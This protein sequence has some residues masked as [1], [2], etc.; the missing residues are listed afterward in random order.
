[1]FR[2]QYLQF[3]DEGWNSIAIIDLEAI[4][5]N[6]K[7]L[8]DRSGAP[9]QMAVVKANAYG[10]GAVDI[11]I[12]VADMVDWFGVAGIREGIE[13]RRQGIMKPILVFGTPTRGSSS[14]YNEYGLT[15]TVSQ[16][17]HFDI[18]QPGT[19]YHIK[20]DTGMGRVGIRSEAAREIVRLVMSRPHLKLGGVMTH[21]ADA[22]ISGSIVFENQLRSF[23]TIRSLFPG[24]LIFHA[25]NSAASLHQSG[26][27]F[28]MIRS[29]VAMYGFDPR[30]D[31]NPWLRPALAW[32]SRLVQV[33]KMKAN[34]GVSYS[35]SF[36]MPHDGYIGVVPVGY[37][38]GIPRRLRN[39][40]RFGI[41]DSE[42]AQ[43]GNITMDQSMVF[44]GREPLS[45]DV[46]VLIMG[47]TDSLS[48]YR[49]ARLLGT[50][51]YEVTTSI[52]N[53]VLRITQ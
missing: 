44:L 49:W 34:E 15:A 23:E 3:F 39:R 33:R 10:H 2:E 50:I 16:I 14:F 41:G 27:G 22:E 30:G 31:W 5:Q 18:L 47:G 11:A 8:K 43:V 12:G 1:M 20:F 37:A 42:Y 19:R 24:D 40:V 6:L 26:T 38:D 35:H 13:L 53:R 17:E 7:Y 36:R 45:T 51:P 4:R 52:G 29:G 46:P 28:D 48:V 32:W 25:S 9:L 21:F